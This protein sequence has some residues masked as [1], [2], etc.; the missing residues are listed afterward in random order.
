MKSEVLVGNLKELGLADF[1]TA[2]ASISI[3][4]ASLLL[5]C[6]LSGNVDSVLSSV[7]RAKETAE[8]K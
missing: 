5:L 4:S 7:L 6:L 3:E 1:N 8:P 2:C